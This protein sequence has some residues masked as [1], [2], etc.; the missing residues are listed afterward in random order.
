M[1]IDR[2]KLDLIKCRIAWY[3][4]FMAIQLR[5]KID[6]GVAR[7]HYVHLIVETRDR[8][9]VGGIQGRLGRD[10]RPGADTGV[11]RAKLKG[12]K[13]PEHH[14]FAQCSSWKPYILYHT[15]IR[16]EPVAARD[17]N[18]SQVTI[19]SSGPIPCC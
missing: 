18:L 1:L 17:L 3:G 19:L 2:P 8:E 12:G 6:V 4:P 15:I 13:Q 5:C 9:F 7:N 10:E 11:C 14:E 16:S